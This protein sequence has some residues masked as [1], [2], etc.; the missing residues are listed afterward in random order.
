L[1]KLITVMM[2]RIS[3]W[4]LV[5]EFPS[6][7]KKCIVVGAPHTS[8]FDFIYALAGFYKLKI[9]IRYL[10]KEDWLKFPLLK[11]LFKKSGA[12]SVNRSKTNTMVDALAESITSAKDSLVLLITPEGTRKYA[13]VWK[14]GF[15]HTA[16]KANVPIVLSSLDYAKKLAIIGPHFMPTGCYKRDMLTLKNFFQ[17]ITPRY[18]QNFCPDIYRVEEDAICSG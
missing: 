18:P 4:K 10:I 1:L 14:T 17:K 2:F 16:L 3:G 12:I 15:Y 9:P 7:I 11:T 8:N 6:H 13:P 5:G